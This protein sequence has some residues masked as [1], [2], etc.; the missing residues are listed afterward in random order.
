[1]MINEF[2]KLTGIYPTRDLYA[3]IEAAYEGDYFYMNNGAAERLAARGGNWYI[4]AN[5][6]VFSFVGYSP[7]SSAG[8]GIGGRSA[9]VD[10]P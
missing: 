2:T 10:L 6:G 8:G 4:G 7:R 9:F 5:G 3:A 1:M